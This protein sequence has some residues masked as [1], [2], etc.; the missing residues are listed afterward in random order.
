MKTEKAFTLIELLVVIAIIA[1]LLA[2]IMPSLQMVKSIARQVVC[3]ARMKQVGAGVI[4]YADTYNGYLP[5]DRDVSGSRWQHSYGVYREGQEVNGKLKPFRFAYLYELNLIEV[6]ELFYCPGNKVDWMKYEFYCDPTPWG[7]LPQ[8]NNGEN[9][10]VRI[11]LTYFPIESHVEINPATNSPYELATK[12]TNL[13][14][15]LPYTTDIIHRLDNISHKIN[16]K[17][18]LNA[19]YKDGHVSTCSDQDVFDGGAYRDGDNPWDVFDTMSDTAQ[20]GTIYYAVFKA[21][22]P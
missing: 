4:M 3:A 13:N 11:G 21:I 8:D 16:D 2:I 1:L 12:H 10:W 20:Y 17:Y 5:D 14:P 15:N 22:G 6:P 18:K 7:T 19:L 9:Q